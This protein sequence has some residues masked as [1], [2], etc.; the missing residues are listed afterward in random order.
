MDE[1]PL[2]GTKAEE[3]VEDLLS[4]A[5]AGRITQGNAASQDV[6]AVA[7]ASCSAITDHT[8]A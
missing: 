4:E 8:N 6:F 3:G 7:S 5:L 2:Q 1:I